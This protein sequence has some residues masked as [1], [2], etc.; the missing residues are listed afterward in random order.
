MYII[1]YIIINK[2]SLGIEISHKLN[3]QLGI[4]IPKAYLPG[5]ANNNTNSI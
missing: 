2:S 3:N 5:S 1:T 4:I